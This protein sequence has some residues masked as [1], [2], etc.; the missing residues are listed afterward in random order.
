M[1]IFPPHAAVAS[2][3][4]PSYAYT[5]PTIIG[6]LR[7]KLSLSRLERIHRLFV[8]LFVTY[9]KW[10]ISGPETR[11]IPLHVLQ[12]WQVQFLCGDSRLFF[13]TVCN[14]HIFQLYQSSWPSPTSWPCRSTSRPCPPPPTR[15]ST[16]WRWDTAHPHQPDR[17]QDTLRVKL[18]TGVLVTR[19]NPD[20]S[21]KTNF[22]V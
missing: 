7:I 2:K 20:S 18:Y 6:N 9:F 21:V 15:P 10:Y 19:S 8:R 12:K 3:R 13:G 17:L 4:R 1:L 22:E 11:Y 14:D 16:P 5:V